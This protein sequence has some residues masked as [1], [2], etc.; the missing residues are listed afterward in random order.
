MHT[1]KLMEYGILFTK[2]ALLATAIW[3]LCDSIGF[4]YYIASKDFQSVEDVTVT[5]NHDDIVTYQPHAHTRCSTNQS[6]VCVPDKYNVFVN[7]TTVVE[8]E[9]CNDVVAISISTYSASFAKEMKEQGFS[10]WSQERIFSL[11]HNRQ[12]EWIGND[13]DTFNSWS[14][15]G[16][17]W[18]E[19]LIGFFMLFCIVPTFLSNGKYITKEQ[20]DD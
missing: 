20:A 5:R 13:Y 14:C 11:F 17:I 15:D 6:D 18:C 19:F 12:Q 7:C 1:N 4:T 3:L 2:L 10:I 16:H 9:V 8:P